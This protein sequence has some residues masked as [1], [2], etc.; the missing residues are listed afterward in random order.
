MASGE[1]SKIFGLGGAVGEK[2][3]IL[4]GSLT[5]RGKSFS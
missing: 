4:R 3:F 1:K 5:M 2:M